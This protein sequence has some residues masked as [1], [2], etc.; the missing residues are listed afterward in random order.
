[1]CFGVLL[2]FKELMTVAI[3]VAMIYYAIDIF[4]GFLGKQLK[5]AKGKKREKE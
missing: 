1:V 2:L 3:T 5:N 4:S